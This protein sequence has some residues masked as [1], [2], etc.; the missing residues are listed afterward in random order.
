VTPFGE[1]L[2][3]A[4]AGVVFTII[5]IAAAVSDVRTRKIPNHLV[6]ALAVTGIVA[7]I[8]GRPIVSG[9]LHGSAGL[10]TG[11]LCWLPFYAAG[12]LGAGD[13]KLFAAASAWLGPVGSLEGTIAAACSGAVLALGW[14][15]RSRGMRGTADVL[16]M[17]AGSPSLLTP[18]STPAQRSTLPYGTAIAFGALWAGWM[19]R[20]LLG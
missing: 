12:W 19:P 11:L 14:M 10:L 18:G 17:A 3:G 16:G 7:S 4:A 15:V 1:S 6:L 9:M 8:A 20:M 2:P 13:V 5:L